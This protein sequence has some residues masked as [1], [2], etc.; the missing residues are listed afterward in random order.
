MGTVRFLLAATVVLFHTTELNWVAGR[1]AVD[2]FFVLSGYVIVNA[3]AR[4]YRGAARRFYVNRLLRL[5]PAYVV[6][7]VATALLMLADGD[8]EGAHPYFFFPFTGTEQKIVSGLTLWDMRPQVDIEHGVPAV[9]FTPLLIPQA[10]SLGVEI[11]FYLAAPLIALLALRGRIVAALG[12]GLGLWAVCV[13]ATADGGNP[14]VLVYKNLAAA[15]ILFCAGAGGSLLR[16]RATLPAPVGIGV[17]I[18][19]VAAVLLSTL[20]TPFGSPIRVGELVA[21]QAATVAAMLMVVLA[22]PLAPG[23]A[24]V[25]RVLGDLSYP[26]FVIHGVAILGLPLVGLASTP[27]TVA[28]GAEMLVASVVL[29]AIVVRWVERPLVAVRARVRTERRVAT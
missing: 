12:V 9:T 27:Y 29:A 22:R 8:L 6:A 2:A 23:A 18:A 14:D 17:G 13:A 1:M 7:A 4:N 28:Y 5:G 11:G 20:V 10:W 24:R 19:Y 16:R 25:D 3:I 15:L 26:M 21:W